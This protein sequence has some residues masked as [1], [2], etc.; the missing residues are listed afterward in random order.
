[1]S[2]I[3][4]LMGVGTKLGRNIIINAVESALD[5]A[6]TQNK[7]KYIALLD[8]SNAHQCV[9]RQRLL[10]KLTAVPDV[11]PELLSFLQ[12]SFQ[13]EVLQLDR[14][15]TV[16]QIHNSSRVQQGCPLSHSLFSFYISDAMTE[17]E[18]ANVEVWG[19]LDDLMMIADTLAELEKSVATITTTLN[20][21]GLSLNPSKT[22]LVVVNNGNLLSE[23][24]ELLGTVI[25][26]KTE[27]KLLG[28]LVTNQQASR[29]HFFE[30]K[31]EKV[32]S[33]LRALAELSHQTHLLFL[34]QCLLAKPIYLLN[35]M[36]ISPT[37]LERADKT[38]T[39]HH[40]SSLG[41]PQ[42]KDLLINVPLKEGGLG[43]PSFA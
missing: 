37:V 6:I 31:M 17:A 20:R 12:H 3:L 39:Q 14:P 11:D 15:G 35:S 25:D 27:V 43:I 10:D 21:D 4:S 33:N 26:T 30:L 23:R 8:I 19:S 40:I 41:I 7:S 38:I 13:Q 16:T 24:V 2:K 18:K 36:L 32:T 22:E 5:E 1:M 28:S 29:D 34:R 42:S 9:R